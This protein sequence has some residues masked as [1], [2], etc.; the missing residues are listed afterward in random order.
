LVVGLSAWSAGVVVVGEMNLA[1]ANSD[2]VELP[3]DV[4]C[5]MP[6]AFA[7]WR[8]GTCAGV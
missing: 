1:R 3:S 8:V 6:C 7:M 2:F 4:W 5:P